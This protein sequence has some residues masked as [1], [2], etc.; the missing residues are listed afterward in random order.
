MDLH[1]VGLSLR[2]VALVE[3][4]AKGKGEVPHDLKSNDGKLQHTCS[5]FSVSQHVRID[6]S[7][8]AQSRPVAET[9]C[10]R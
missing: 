7:G 10:T 1:R 8:F 3:A 9:R 4:E 2:R 5:T 6:V